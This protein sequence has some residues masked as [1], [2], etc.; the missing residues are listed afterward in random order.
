MA[1][2]KSYDLLT[3]KMQESIR[4]RDLDDMMI[5][6]SRR[7]E[8]A[9][10]IEKVDSALQEMTPAREKEQPEMAAKLRGMPERNHSQIKKVLEQIAFKEADLIPLIRGESEELKKELVRMRE[11]RCATASY[12]KPWVSS[13]RFLDASK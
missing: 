8:I 10:K 13:P 11:A 3:E 2:L 12:Y 5:Q 4:E 9:R 1:L 7:G 6:L